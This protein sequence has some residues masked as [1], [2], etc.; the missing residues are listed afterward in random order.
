ME[1]S[2]TGSLSP[3]HVDGRLTER[4]ADCSTAFPARA[5]PVRPHELSSRH[6]VR[7][8]RRH[9]TSPSPRSIDIWPTIVQPTTTSTSLRSNV[10]CCR[11]KDSAR[12][13]LCNRIVT[14]AFHA[15]IQLWSVMISNDGG[16]VT[17]EIGEIFGDAD[18]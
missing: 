4:S 15:T 9:E 10:F 12:W 3:R 13:H 11:M 18:S 1:P 17:R 7:V 14:A 5:T 2:T 16:L 6:S 8:S